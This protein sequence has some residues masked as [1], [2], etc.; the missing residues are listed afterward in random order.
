MN[1]N[2]SISHSPHEENNVNLP[3]QEDVKYL[4]L[5][6]ER[7]LTWRKHIFTKPKQMGM[8]LTKMHWLLGRKSKLTTSNTILIYKAILSPIWTYGIKVWDTASISD[9]EILERFQYKVLSTIVDAP[10]YVPNTVIGRD[11]QTP[12]V[13]EDIRHYSSQYSALLSVHTND[14]VVNLMAQPDNRRLLR[15]VPNNRHSRFLV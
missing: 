11:L 7:R 9:I 2:R 15:Q 8:T 3:R 4:G 5:H 14:V 12:T 13:T 10:W 6:L 1:P